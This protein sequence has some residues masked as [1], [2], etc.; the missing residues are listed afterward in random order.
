MNHVFRDLLRLKIKR[1]NFSTIL[2][3]FRLIM[4]NDEPYFRVCFHGLDLNETKDQFW[5]EY[6]RST[7]TWSRICLECSEKVCDL[8]FYFCQFHSNKE[9]K[10]KKNLKRQLKRLN[11]RRLKNNSLALNTISNDIDD[12]FTHN[13]NAIVISIS[14]SLTKKQIVKKM[15]SINLSTNLRFIYSY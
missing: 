1:N 4:F 7:R 15:L 3:T 11:Q 5:T 12:G 2:F 14:S 8:S 13:T 9:N 6:N 10:T